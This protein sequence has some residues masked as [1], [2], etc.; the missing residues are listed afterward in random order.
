MLISV[1]LS[2]NLQVIILNPPGKGKRESK[3]GGDSAKGEEKTKL[4]GV[5][6]A[7]YTPIVD[8]HTA[9][10]ACKFEKIV[11]KIDRRSGKVLEENPEYLVKGDAAMIILVPQKPMC[12]ESFADYPPLGRFACR[13]GDDTVAVGIIKSVEKVGK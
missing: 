4:K 2:I 9:H 5:I 10:V 12:V 11:E 6:K 7:G 1:I 3:I 8:C 13:S